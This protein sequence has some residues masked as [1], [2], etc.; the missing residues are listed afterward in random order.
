MSDEHN[1]ASAATRA[2]G[3][4]HSPAAHRVIARLYAS[5]DPPLRGRLLACLLRPLS[6]LGIVAVAAGAFAGVLHRDGIRV[7]IDEAARFSGAQVAELAHF[8]E[9]VEP[10]A[11]QQFATLTAN[12]PAALT[13]FG[14]AAVVLL[15][16]ALR[17]SGTAKTEALGN[18]ATERP[19]ATTR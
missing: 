16:R 5:A 9:Q 12:N 15:V 14:A 10:N 7:A 4:G 8:V 3:R 19:P 2:R 18:A 17:E 1:K 13:T 11:L 6:P